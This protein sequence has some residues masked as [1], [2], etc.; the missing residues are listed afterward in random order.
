GENAK[1]QKN[2]AKRLAPITKSVQ[3]RKRHV[4]RADLQRQ[5]VIYKPKQQRHGNEENHRGAVHGEKLVEGVG[6]KEMIVRHGQLQTEQKRFDSAD[7]EKEKAGQHVEH[8][9]ALV[10]HSRKPG[11][12]IV[13]ALGWVENDVPELC[14]AIRAVHFSVER[15]VDN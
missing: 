12:L 9:D 14:D 10:I 13:S 1:M 8:A 3:A 2:S 15:Y 11:E 7:D 6:G 4:T 5:D